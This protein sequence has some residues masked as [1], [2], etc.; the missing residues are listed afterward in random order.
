MSSQK[1]NV[2]KSRQ[3][4]HQNSSS[5]K[6]TKYEASGKIK[7]LNNMQILGVC[8]HCKEKIEWKIKYKKYKALTAPRRCNKCG[9]KSVKRAY[10]ILCMPCS[11]QDKVCAM[12]NKHEPIVHQ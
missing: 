12:C 6:N 3:Q 2:K 7:E 9:E 10:Y 5:F 11:T 8:Q 4:R 1:G